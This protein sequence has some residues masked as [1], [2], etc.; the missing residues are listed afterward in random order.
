[1]IQSEVLCA[2]TSFH[3]AA[4][5][6][7]NRPVAII[8]LFKQYVGKSLTPI[9]VKPVNSPGTYRMYRGA[10]IY[11]GFWVKRAVSEHYIYHTIGITIE[12]IIIDQS[13]SLTTS[14]WRISA[15]T[16]V[17]CQPLLST[18]SPLFCCVICSLLPEKP[19][20]GDLVSFSGAL[21]GF[22]QP[23]SRPCRPSGCWEV[24]P[25]VHSL[26]FQARDGG[27]NRARDPEDQ[28]GKRRSV[29]EEFRCEERF[30]DI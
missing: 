15:K 6:L 5:Y 12:T 26:G 23:A 2:E 28:P 11:T 3:F 27:N 25:A 29:A 10:R 24:F 14:R 21:S 13:I 4:K 18:L 8:Q 1:M 16:A 7:E 17:I 19:V 30:L 22:S 20:A 9:F